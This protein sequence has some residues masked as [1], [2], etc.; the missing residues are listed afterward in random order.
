MSE[1]EA[2]PTPQWTVELDLQDLNDTAQLAEELAG[3]LRAGD[4]LILTGGLGAGKTTF[5][6]A[7]AAA[8]GVQGRVSSPTF[9][10][11]RVHRGTDDGPDLVHVDAYRTDAEGFEDL[12]LLSSAA[13]AVTV[14]EWGRG[15]A[16]KSLTGASGSW[17]DLELLTEAEGDGVGSDPA[18]SRGIVTDFSESDDDV[19]GAARRALLR[20][21]GPR[22]AQA[23]RLTLP[24]R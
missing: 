6:Q 23:P 13:E 10:L 2:G 1:P 18:D 20:G 22:W 19:L 4:L 24:R 5:T 3:Y 14:V 9:V 16:E 21:V 7:L 17:L 11:S 15:L 12:D 8:L